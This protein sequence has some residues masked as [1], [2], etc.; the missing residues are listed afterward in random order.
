M[1]GLLGRMATWVECELTVVATQCKQ[2][3][4]HKYSREMRGRLPLGKSLRMPAPAHVVW[5]AS[6]LDQ[7]HLAINPHSLIYPGEELRSTVA[8]EKIHATLQEM[9]APLGDAQNR[10]AL[11]A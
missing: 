1:A 5:L 10:H 7:S 6:E 3:S 2:T 11:A 8:Q 9:M 4:S